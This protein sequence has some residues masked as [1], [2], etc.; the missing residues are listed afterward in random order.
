M[1]YFT[2]VDTDDAGENLAHNLNLPLMQYIFATAKWSGFG[3][4]KVFAALPA[5]PTNR[6]LTNADLYAMFHLTHEEQQHVE[7]AL[8]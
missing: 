6:R 1:I 5:L 8:A 7:C 3:N 2:R 4:E